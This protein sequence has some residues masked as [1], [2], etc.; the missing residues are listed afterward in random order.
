MKK[1]KNTVSCL[2]NLL[3]LKRDQI[4]S[5]NETKKIDVGKKKSKTHEHR[6]TARDHRNMK[7]KFMTEMLRFNVF[8]D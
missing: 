5:K 3:M 6:Q 4:R 2:L 7:I 8:K 1:T